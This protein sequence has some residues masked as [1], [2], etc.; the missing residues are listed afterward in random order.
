ME[1]I[2]IKHSN[3]K[4][5]ID[6]YYKPTDTHRCLPFSSNYPSHC[7]K[8]IPFTLARRIWTIV[9]NTET[10]NETFRKS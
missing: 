7:K 4:I 10:K 5:W 8:Y 1:Y 6:I 2:L 3:D 9:E